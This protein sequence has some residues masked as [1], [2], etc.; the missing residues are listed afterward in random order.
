M[1]LKAAIKKWQAEFIKRTRKT[2]RNREAIHRLINGAISAGM[3]AATFG[4]STAAVAQDV[5]VGVGPAGVYVGAA[6][7]GPYGS[8]YGYAGRS[9]WYGAAHDIYGGPPSDL[10]SYEGPNRAAQERAH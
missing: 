4:L 8:P 1:Q 10:F 7:E 6:P 9:R 5:G 3:L 2:M